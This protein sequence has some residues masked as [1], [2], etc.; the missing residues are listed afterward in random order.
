MLSKKCQYALHALQFMAEQPLGKQ[1]T[2]QEIATEKNIPKKFLEAILHDLKT[3]GILASKK[4]KLGGYCLNRM[5]KDVN[6]LEV[7]RT[8]DGAVAML[9][10]VSL[11]FYASC[12]RCENESI[13]AINALFRQV[14]DE[15]LK[16]LSANTLEDLLKKPILAELTDK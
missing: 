16:I 3:A 9:P 13:C 12:G 11:N 1:L 15:T 14:R 5:A 4:G 6:V 7:I 8:I 10:C 2:I